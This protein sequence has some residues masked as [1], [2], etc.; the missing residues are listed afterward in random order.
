KAKPGVPKII[1]G[2][3]D[4]VVAK[5]ASLIFEV[6]VEGEVEEVR[7]AKDTT[8]I[9]AGTNAVIEKIDDKT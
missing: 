8:P 1:K 4:Q 5:G 3:E 6:K 9:T 7:W 2:L